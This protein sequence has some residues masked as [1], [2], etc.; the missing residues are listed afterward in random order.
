MDQRFESVLDRSM[1]HSRCETERKRERERKSGESKKE[2][3]REKGRENLFKK[4]M[5]TSNE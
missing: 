3:D 5:D 1:L 2:G 4:G